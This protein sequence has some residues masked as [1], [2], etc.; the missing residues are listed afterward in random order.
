MDKES[1]W[2]LQSPDRQLVFNLQLDEGRLYYRLDHSGEEVVRKSR[3][4]VVR[5]D[6]D[7]ANDLSFKVRSEPE[8]SNEKISFLTGKQVEI[9]VESIAQSFSFQNSQGNV[10]EVQAK[11][12]DGGLALRYVFP[13]E[14][15]ELVTIHD[16]LMEFRLPENGH[17]WLQP[18]D[19]ITRYTP[20]YEKYYVNGEPLGMVGN[21][22]NG[23]C[24]PALFNNG[25]HWLLLSEAGIDGDYSGTH[26]DNLEG[27]ATYTLRWPETSEANAIGSSQP[28]GKLPWQTS[29][30]TMAVG[31]LNTIIKSELVKI[32]AAPSRI[33]DTSW[34]KPGR[35]SW[36]WL[37]DH[38][39]PKDFNK[40]KSF[41]DLAADMQWEYSLVD[42]NW[43][44]MEGG[45]IDELVAYAKQKRVGILMWYNSG[46]PHN[47]VTEA[48]RNIMNDRSS[49]RKEFERLQKLGVKGVKIDFFQ[50]DKEVMMKLYK[51]IL[52][53]A[54]EFKIMVNFHGCT[55]PRGWS[56]TYPNLMTMESVR[57]AESYTFAEDY[58]ANAPE[59]NTILPFTRNVIG[60]MDYTPVIFTHMEYPH[61]T[62]NGH[63]MALAVLFESGW[64][65]FG[66]GVQGYQ[67]LGEKEKAFLREIPV[68]WDQLEF[69]S[70]TPGKE[71]I[72]ARRKGDSWYLAG[73]NGE[74]SSKKWEIDLSVFP[75]DYSMLKIV[76]GT[77]PD[78]LA[79]AVE[80]KPDKLMVEV[81]PYGGFTLRLDPEPSLAWSK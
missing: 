26:L 10:I 38:P 18:Y 34:I 67:S 56:R 28:N 39:S 1:Q 13:D 11:I 43:D 68:T 12:I 9:E 27:S 33:D 55:I 48:P 14:T 79:C 20:A 61:I 31:D 22:G 81:L 58:P 8:N 47:E 60:S 65:H 62:S 3:L 76:D 78:Q 7:L 29:W 49:R 23:W 70:G 42:A 75:G 25:S 51:E 16:D 44:Q 19:E 17:A 21:Y 80:P 71:V 41:I 57:G 4:G 36:S 37:S 35:A 73:I 52:D 63:E 40:L 6:A 72:L 24:F 54:V 50:S 74:D 46:G 15:N 77:T 5:S 32:L 64:L 69:I 30:K 66:D 2:R 45:T 53:D 59:L